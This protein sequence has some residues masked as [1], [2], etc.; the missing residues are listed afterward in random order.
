MEGAAGS[1]DDDPGFMVSSE[2]QLLV[3]EINKNL[4]DARDHLHEWKEAARESYDFFAGHQWSQEDHQ[5]LNEESRPT[6]VFNRVPRVINAVA[7]LEIQNRQE[8]TYYPRTSGDIV[9]SNIL[10]SAA[11]WVRD[12]CDAEDEE[13][14][15]FKDCLMTGL[16]FV[17]TRLDYEVDPDGTILIERVDP[18]DMLYDPTSQKRNLDDANW[19]ARVRYYNKKDFFAMWPEAEDE[20]ITDLDTDP[21]GME[22]HD[23]TLAP[24]YI[25]DQSGEVE[26]REHKDNEVQVVQYQYWIRETFYRVELLSGEVQE[27]DKDEFRKNRKEIMLTATR[28]LKQYRKQYRQVFLAGTYILEKGDC[29]VDGFTFRAI[30]GLV[31][32]SKGIWLGL[33]ELM[34]DPQRWANKWLSQ[35]LHIVNSNAKGGYFAETDAFEDN[36][37]AEQSLATTSITWVNEGALAA[38]KIEKKEPPI[39]PSQVDALLKYAIDSIA[40]VVGVNLEMLGVANRDQAALLERERKRAGITVVSDFFDA[41][42]RYRKEEGRI[43]AEYIIKYISDGRLIKIT[44]EGLGQY[45]PLFK[46]DLNFKYDIVVDESP[47][48]PN[49]R[50]LIWD[51]LVT[52]LPSLLQANIPIPPD[53]LDYAPFPAQMVISWKKAIEEASQ[54]NEQMQK[55]EA[56]RMQLAE[57]ETKLKAAEAEKLQ[58]QVTETKTKSALN[59]AKTGHEEALANLEGSKDARASVQTA[60]SAFKGL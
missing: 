38:N 7:G 11:N 2:D 57:L 55:E 35:T 16:G 23:A 51:R 9:G 44:G 8:V 25:N 19:I 52:L 21:H 47:T 42:R 27:F 59:M 5:K 20:M 53:I 30:S 56:L 54:P 12:N 49:Q 4:K 22:P 50:E 18:L 41:L 14:Q 15:S 46:K 13:S 24:W 10:T 34:K 28:Y 39:F 36:R 58:A 3:K 43:L 33:I 29:P 37:Q 40:E 17:E 48:A 45:V 60:I 31:D 26:E 1:Q 32:H 6:I